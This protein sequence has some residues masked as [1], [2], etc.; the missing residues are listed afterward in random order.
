M[1]RLNWRLWR[2]SGLRF[3]PGLA[4]AILPAPGPAGGA[5]F[6]V[7]GTAPRPVSIEDSRVASTG[8]MRAEYGKRRAEPARK[9]N[10]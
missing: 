6:G 9:D 8:D 3:L 4:Q 10:Q 7:S 5:G 2:F 1:S